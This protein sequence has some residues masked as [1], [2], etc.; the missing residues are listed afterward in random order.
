MQTALC[1]SLRIGHA[2]GDKEFSRKIQQMIKRTIIKTPPQELPSSA[3][4]E[5]DKSTKYDATLVI[6]VVLSYS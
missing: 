4:K 6:V 5:L 1:S 2:D 3:S